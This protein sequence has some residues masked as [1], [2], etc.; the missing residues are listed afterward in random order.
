MVGVFAIVAI[1]AIA[2]KRVTH[3]RCVRAYLMR[4]AR[5][6]AKDEELHAE[7]EAWNKHDGAALEASLRHDAKLGGA[8]VRLLDA[9]FLIELWRYKGRLCRRQALP[10]DAFLTLEQLQRMPAGGVE[11]NCLR[12]AAVA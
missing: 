12:V 10:N 11:A 1:F 2:D 3:G 7:D 9:R 5:A 8:P 4:A 6:R